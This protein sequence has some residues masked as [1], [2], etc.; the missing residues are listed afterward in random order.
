M[1]YFLFSGIAYILW[2]LLLDILNLFLIVVLH[3]NFVI[4]A[5]M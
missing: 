1:F 2:N 5:Y 3:I 4:F